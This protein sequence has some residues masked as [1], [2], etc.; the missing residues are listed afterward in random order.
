MNRLKTAAK[1]A[2]LIQHACNLSG[3]LHTWHKHMDALWAEARENGHG[4]DWVNTHPINQLFSDK[5]AQMTQG[6]TS[7]YSAA[8]EVCQKLAEE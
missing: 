3:V 8:Y 6:T 5:V 7:G 4:T 2:L 1:D